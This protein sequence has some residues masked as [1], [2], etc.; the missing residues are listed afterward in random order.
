[1]C[2]IVGYIGPQKAVPVILD[3]P[4]RREHCLREAPPAQPRAIEVEHLGEVVDAPREDRRRRERVT[5]E[6]AR[7]GL[8]LGFYLCGVAAA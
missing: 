2:G 7:L 8:F 6:R 4:P 3:R 1:M 5:E